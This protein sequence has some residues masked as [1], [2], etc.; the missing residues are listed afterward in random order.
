VPRQDDAAKT[1]NAERSRHD[2]CAQGVQFRNASF[3]TTFD[4]FGPYAAV[5]RVRANIN[6]IAWSATS[7]VP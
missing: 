3:G 2:A 1:D 5:P 6:P 4:D 7:V